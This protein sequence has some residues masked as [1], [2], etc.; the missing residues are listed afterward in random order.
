VEETESQSELDKYL[1]L[2]YIPV[3]D[4]KFAL[5]YEP[6]RTDATVTP[7]EELVAGEYSIL[8][9]AETMEIV[10]ARNANER[11]NPA[12]MTKVLTIL[13]AAEHVEDLSQKVVI[14][15]EA[16]NYSFVNDCSNASLATGDVFTVEDLFYMTILPSGGDAAIALALHCAGSVDTFVEW[17]NEKLVELGLSETS[18]FT[19]PVG[20]YD[21]DLYSTASD[22]AMIMKAAEENEFCRQVLTAHTY[23]LDPCE[24][25]EEGLC[26]SNLFLR[27][28]ED[29]I[30]SGLVLGAKT[31]YVDQ[32]G[33]CAVSYEVSNSGTPYICVVGKSSS[34]WGC[35]FDHVA[36]YDHYAK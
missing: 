10:A 7:S 25:H 28:I 4:M 35:I 27:R 11:M 15:F 8:V 29:H 17:M 33:S 36:I 18:H 5:G 3:D 9:N 31:G 24:N 20:I 30:E 19:N 26:Y 34:S 23:V 12:S 6:Y 13:V 1:E 14:P 32:S 22:I 21:E 2:G 16:T